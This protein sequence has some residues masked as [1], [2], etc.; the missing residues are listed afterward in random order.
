MPAAGRPGVG[1][2]IL[3]LE[4]RAGRPASLGYD[5][6]AGWSAASSP[7]FFD[8]RRRGLIQS[9]LPANFLFTLTAVSFDFADVCERKSM[10]LRYDL[11]G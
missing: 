8:L 5:K 4:R 11:D 2:A 3:M 1:K 7:G 10:P 9:E 6:L